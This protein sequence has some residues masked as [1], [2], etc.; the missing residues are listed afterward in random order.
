M[1]RENLI[2]IRLEH[3]EA[4]ESRRDVLT[5][6]ADLIK[7]AQTIKKYKILR[8][9][10][11]ALKIELYRKVKEFKND[12]RKLHTLLPKIQIPKILKRHEDEIHEEIVVKIDS[13]PKKVKEIKE[14]KEI[15]VKKPKDELEEQLMEIQ[16]KLNK[17]G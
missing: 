7:I 16:E 13:K 6:E 1:S 8:L 10:E 17:L 9:K 3:E 14:K 4:V 12:E 15:P 11:L 5:T 2:H